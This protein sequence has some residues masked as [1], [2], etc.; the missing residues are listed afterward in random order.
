MARTSADLRRLRAVAPLVVCKSAALVHAGLIVL[1]ALFPDHQRGDG[2]KAAQI[3]AS[4]GHGPVWF[5]W[6]NAILRK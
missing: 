6:T 2:A 3:G 5:V 1:P 4:S